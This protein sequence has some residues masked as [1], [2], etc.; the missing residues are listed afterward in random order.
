M[1][2]KSNDIPASSKRDAF[3]FTFLRQSLHSC[4]RSFSV[5]WSRQLGFTSRAG[6]V[7]GPRMGAV[8]FIFTATGQLISSTSGSLLLNFTHPRRLMNGL[9]KTWNP[10]SKSL[11]RV[12]GT[13]GKV[14]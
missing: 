13:I 4:L 6:P 10:W 11:R 7:A 5:Y 8:V 14:A 9:L 2:G 12:Q 3:L 1:S